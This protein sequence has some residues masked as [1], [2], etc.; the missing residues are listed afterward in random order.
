M[1]IPGQKVKG[2]LIDELSVAYDKCH[3]FYNKKVYM[4]TLTLTGILSRCVVVTRIVRRS[5]HTTYGIVT[6]LPTVASWF[7]THTRFCH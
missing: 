5:D 6:L 4:E 1:K 2:Q 3:V 7:M